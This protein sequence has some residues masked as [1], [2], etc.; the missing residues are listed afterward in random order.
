MLIA[1][2]YEEIYPHQN[3]TY[4]K[5]SADAFNVDELKEAERKIFKTLNFKIEPNPTSYVFLQKFHWILNLTQVQLCFSNMLLHLLLHDYNALR[6][7]P[8][9]LAVSAIMISKQ[10]DDS[11]ME[12]SNH[13]SSSKTCFDINQVRIVLKQSPLKSDQVL[14]DEIAETIDYITSHLFNCFKNQQNL[15][16]TIKK[17]SLSKYCKVSD[18]CS[19]LSK[20]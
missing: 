5:L 9:L 13:L 19:N 3:E 16:Y 10:I 7:K 15:K 6:I 20:S 14:A 17:F 18:M 8:S 1:E 4:W 2:K 11:S 12:K